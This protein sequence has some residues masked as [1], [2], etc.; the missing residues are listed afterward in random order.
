[1]TP[2]S[3]LRNP[4]CVSE[5]KDFTSGGFK[6][7]IDDVK[8]D[9]KKVN[10]LVFCTGKL[11]YDLI[12]ERE[13]LKNEQVA[14]VRIEQLHPFPGKQIKALKEKYKNAK[15]CIWAQ[16]EP[17]NM[18]AW[19]YIHKNMLPMFDIKVISR[20]ASGSTA[21]GSVKF[22][23]VRHQKILDKVFSECDCPYIDEEC[24]MAC[25]GNKWK[26]FEKEIKELQ[27]DTIDCKFHSGTKPLK[28]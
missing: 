6:E 25:I 20:P 3:L 14:L 23:I 11:F 19:E 13:K 28:N 1:M 21:T 22:H 27:V 17:A 4:A 24:K 26:S 5:V 9:L 18:G 8:A 15:T 10:K 16:E 12:A 2:K 7:V